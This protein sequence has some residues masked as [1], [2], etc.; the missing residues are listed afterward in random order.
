M[1]KRTLIT[2]VLLLLSLRA[3]ASEYAFYSSLSPNLRKFLSGH[4]TAVNAFTNAVT[5]AFSNRTARVFCFYSDDPDERQASHF[6]P[7][8]RGVPDVVICVAQDSY[9]LDEFINVV[10]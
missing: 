1:N 4:P 8:I 6:Y 5:G 2:L 7:N 3:W 10:F 9:P